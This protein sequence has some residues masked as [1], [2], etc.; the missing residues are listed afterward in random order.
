MRIEPVGIEKG[1]RMLGGIERF[2]TAKVA[3]QNLGSRKRRFL[4]IGDN[5]AER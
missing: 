3:M 2:H 5:F 4:P 1:L